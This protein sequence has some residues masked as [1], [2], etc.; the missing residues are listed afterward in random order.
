MQQLIASPGGGRDGVLTFRIVHILWTIFSSHVGIQKLKNEF[1]N[2]RL[3][4]WLAHWQD[5]ILLVCPLAD[6]ARQKHV[7]GIYF[8]EN[9]EV[10]TTRPVGIVNVKCNM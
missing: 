2:K 6:W 3:M 9:L 5:L 1:E 8:K 4:C 10:I 7:N